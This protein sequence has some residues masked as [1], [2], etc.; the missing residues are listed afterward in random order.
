MA[1]FVRRSGSITDPEKSRE[2]FVTGNV[3]ARRKLISKCGYIHDN[4]YSSMDCH[5]ISRSVCLIFGNK[6]KHVLGRF[7]KSRF[8]KKNFPKNRGPNY[9]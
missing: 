3:N 7:H 1:R 6:P 5:M 4:T 8:H 2:A 9:E